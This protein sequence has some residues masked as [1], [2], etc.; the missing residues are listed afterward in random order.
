MKNT[1]LTVLAWRCK[2]RSL[3]MHR[4]EATASDSRSTMSM[5]LACMPAMK[6]A[7]GSTMVVANEYG[8]T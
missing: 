6:Q 8:S 2:H 3:T 7:A 5:A 4:L 1:A